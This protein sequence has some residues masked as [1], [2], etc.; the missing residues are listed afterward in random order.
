MRI[1]QT[2]H[3]K[4]NLSSKE[5]LAGPAAHEAQKSPSKSPSAEAPSPSLPAANDELPLKELLSERRANKE[6]LKAPAAP[7]WQPFSSENPT[8]LPCMT[9]VKLPSRNPDAA[10][11]KKAEKS[12][13]PRTQGKLNLSSGKSAPQQASVSGVGV[14]KEASTE[15]KQQ[16]RGHQT[17]KKRHSTGGL[18]P[19]YEDT[20]AKKPR[21]G[22]LTLEKQPQEGVSEVEQDAASVRQAAEKAAHMPR[23]PY[24]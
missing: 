5:R 14:S 21:R 23:D 17:A 4:P 10:A 20:R 24:R 22:S 19:R 18:S 12:L 15:G 16:G 11:S 9:P 13:T 7:Q 1:G 6:K 3:T 2:T 8:M